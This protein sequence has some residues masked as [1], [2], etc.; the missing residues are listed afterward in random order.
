M[1]ISEFAFIEQENFHC[2]SGSNS[3][4][5]PLILVHTVSVCAY[6]VYLRLVY[7]VKMRLF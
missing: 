5:G 3:S 1:G 2:A 6:R 4:I 7:H